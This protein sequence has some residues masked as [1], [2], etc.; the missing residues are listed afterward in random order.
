VEGRR[1]KGE[2]ESV[3]GWGEKEAKEYA[4]KRPFIFVPLFG[5]CLCNTQ[6]FS[7]SH[8]YEQVI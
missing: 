4:A 2:K 5:S 3:E 1:K 6:K 8:A 7:I